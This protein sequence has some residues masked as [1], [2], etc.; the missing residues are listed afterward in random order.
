[1]E[2]VGLRPARDLDEGRPGVA[3]IAHELVLQG[4]GRPQRLRG[5]V[6]DHRPAHMVVQI[7]HHDPAR[8]GP[9]R[10]FGHRTRQLDVLDEAP[11]RHDLAWLD[12]HPTRT[13]SSA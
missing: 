10:L 3:E 4:Q 7:L 12:V 13:T 6:D 1:V 11:D 2:E 8:A 9:V 5:R